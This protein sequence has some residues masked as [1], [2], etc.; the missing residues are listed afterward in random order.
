MAL[1]GLKVELG[2][3]E[4][5]FIGRRNPKNAAAIFFFKLDIVIINLKTRRANLLIRFDNLNVYH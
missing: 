3:A 2:E 1:S 4:R 5:T